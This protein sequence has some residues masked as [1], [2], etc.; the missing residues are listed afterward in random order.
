MDLKRGLNKALHPSNSPSV[1]TLIK[2]NL[3]KEGT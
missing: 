3:E 2:A 1:P